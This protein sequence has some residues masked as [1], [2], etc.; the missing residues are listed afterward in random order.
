MKKNVLDQSLYS[1][2]EKEDGGEISLI[3]Q[4]IFKQ[5]EDGYWFGHIPT[6]SECYITGITRDIAKEGLEIK[7]KALITTLFEREGQLGLDEVVL[8][9]GVAIIRCPV[10]TVTV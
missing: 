5:Q 9:G 4:A 1:S 10:I 6:L 7:A 8:G 3:F 2:F